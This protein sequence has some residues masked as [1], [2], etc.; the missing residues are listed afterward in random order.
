MVG[1]AG[2]YDLAALQR[3]TAALQLDNKIKDAEI[4]EKTEKIQEKDDEIRSL[5]HEYEVLCSS[6]AAENSR[7]LERIFEECF[8][9]SSGSFFF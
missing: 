1:S 6:V 5:R 4:K 2:E 3:Q 9:N 8:S 7:R